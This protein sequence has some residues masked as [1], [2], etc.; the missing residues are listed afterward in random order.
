LRAQFGQRR[1]GLPGDQRLQTLP[2]AC[3]QQRL[4][5]TPVSLW[6][7]RPAG[8]EVL[9]HPPHGG[10]TVAEAGGDFAGAFALVVKVKYSLTHWNRNGFHAKT[11]PG[12]Q[13]PCKL[14]NLWK[15]SSGLD[16][17]KRMLLF[18][19]QPTNQNK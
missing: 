11:L 9:A 13:P 4:A 10:N 15:C 17:V 12:Q 7:Q 14:H 16:F 8:F 3:R 1:V 18:T 6:F 2:A 19:H 5:L